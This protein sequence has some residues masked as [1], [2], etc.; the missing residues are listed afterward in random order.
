MAPL[1]KIIR[2]PQSHRATRPLYFLL[3]D[4]N[5]ALATIPSF[6]SLDPNT[7][8]LT[9]TPVFKAPIPTV[10]TSALPCPSDQYLIPPSRLSSHREPLCEPSLA[11]YRPQE[12]ACLL[13]EALQQLRTH[14]TH[15]AFVL[16]QTSKKKPSQVDMI[17]LNFPDK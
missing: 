10:H 13:A 2:C 1:Q 9:S 6:A 15:F 7:M 14:I 4:G 3:M 17:L 12:L 16:S 8:V 5:L 11:V